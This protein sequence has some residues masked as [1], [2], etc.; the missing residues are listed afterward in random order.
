MV[1]I[2]GSIHNYRSFT[3][4]E[5]RRETNMVGANHQNLSSSGLD[6]STKVF[7]NLYH[8]YNNTLDIIHIF[9]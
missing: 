3:R 1:G 9:I 8:N 5:L 7:E 4:S 2:Q 6:Q